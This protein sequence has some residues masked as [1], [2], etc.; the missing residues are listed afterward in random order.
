[1]GN[2]SSNRN[3]ELS[4]Y[5]RLKLGYIRYAKLC[6][7]STEAAEQRINSQVCNEFVQAEL[8]FIVYIIIPIAQ[9]HNITGILMHFELICVLFYKYFNYILVSQFII[10]YQSVNPIQSVHYRACGFLDRNIDSFYFFYLHSLKSFIPLRNL[11]SDLTSSSILPF[12]DK[13]TV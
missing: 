2:K 11:F 1:M 7:S 6:K 10:N 8:L 9:L 12:R 3:N 5:T 4:H 13:T